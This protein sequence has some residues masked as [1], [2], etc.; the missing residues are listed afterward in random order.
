M[1]STIGAVF[2]LTQ[3]QQATFTSVHIYYLSVHRVITEL[4]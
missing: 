1:G 2:R 4:L 3:F